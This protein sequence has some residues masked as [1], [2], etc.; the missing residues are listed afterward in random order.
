MNKEKNG[1]KIQVE[2]CIKRLA[3]TTTI[4]K[5]STQKTFRQGKGT[6]D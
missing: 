5:K 3:E 2:L 4:P 1:W 6:E